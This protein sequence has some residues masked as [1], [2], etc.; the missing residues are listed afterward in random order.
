MKLERGTVT[1]VIL[2]LCVFSC[3]ANG[4]LEIVDNLP[5][6]FIDISVDG[7][8]LNLSGDDVAQI[9]TTMG[10][11]L[12]P[13]GRVVVSNNGGMGFDP[14]VDYLAPVNQPR[15]SK[16]AFGG[17]QV[18][19]AFW[20]DIGNE[21]GDVLWYEINYTLIVQWHD[22]TFEGSSDSARFQ[23]QIFDTDHPTEIFGQLLYADIEQPRPAGGGSATIGY[24]NGG[25]QFNDVQWSYN[26]AG[27][28]ANGTVLSLIPE[29]SM[30]VLMVVVG[31]ALLRRQ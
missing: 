14:P 30:G 11:A 22:H 28:V 9:T 23:I 20:D 31:L 29:P 12:F 24:Q 1:A 3:A 5:G 27:A 26:L 17:G 13:S 8:P 15:P 6:T 7:T 18:M 21:M 16:D 10:N 4:A 19:M 25:R 2:A